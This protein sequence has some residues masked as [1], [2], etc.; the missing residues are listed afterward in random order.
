MEFCIDYKKLEQLVQ[1]KNFNIT[2]ISEAFNVV[3]G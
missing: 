3:D 1:F 2:I